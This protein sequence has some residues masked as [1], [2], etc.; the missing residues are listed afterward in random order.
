MVNLLL[1]NVPAPSVGPQLRDVTLSEFRPRHRIAGRV[2]HGAGGYLFC[3]GDVRATHF[4]G[5]GAVT[6][7][8]C[9]L[10]RAIVDEVPLAL[11]PGAAHVA[12]S[13]GHIKV[14]VSE[15]RLSRQLAGRE[16]RLD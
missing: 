6:P 9:R 3:E 13:L 2:R 12:V 4:D 10:F 14:C 1:P 8:N 5:G 7:V 15:F 16:M 11:V